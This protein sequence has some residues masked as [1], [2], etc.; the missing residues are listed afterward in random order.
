MRSLLCLLCCLC[1]LIPISS[2][3]PFIGH[4]IVGSVDYQVLPNGDVYFV[5]RAL[6]D[7]LLLYDVV[8]NYWCCLGGVI[9]SDPRISYTT[10]DGMII[11]ALGSD[12]CVWSYIRDHWIQISDRPFYS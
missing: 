10:R 6:N 2:S 12:Y 3:S 4:E 1:I 9:V 11:T 5:A 8:N 7:S